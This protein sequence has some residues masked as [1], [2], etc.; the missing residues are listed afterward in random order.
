ML[1]HNQVISTKT[2]YAQKDRNVA[3]KPFFD[4]NMRGYYTSSVVQNRQF[5]SSHLPENSYED[6]FKAISRAGMNLVRYL[7]YWEAYEKNPRLLEFADF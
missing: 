7:L 2:V 3:Y 4:F 1:S 6:S 5:G